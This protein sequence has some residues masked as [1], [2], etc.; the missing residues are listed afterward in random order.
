MAVDWES[1]WGVCEEWAA[2][3]E[4]GVAVFEERVRRNVERV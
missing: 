3:V 2:V 1:E 4:R